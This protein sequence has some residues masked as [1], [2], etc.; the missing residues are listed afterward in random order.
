MDYLEHHGVKG[1]KWGVRRY[2]NPDGT[3]TVE[4]KRRVSTYA[5]PKSTENPY[6]KRRTVKIHKSVERLDAES[7]KLNKIQSVYGHESK[8]FKRQLKIQNN[9][10]GAY[11][12][13]TRDPTYTRVHDR[14]MVGQFLGGPVGQ[15]V[16]TVATKE[17][18]RCI[19]EWQN[20]IDEVA[21]TADFASQVR[22]QLGK[23]YID[24][25]WKSNKMPRRPDIY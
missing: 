9:A 13:A 7:D 1:Q 8:Q 20:R 2:Q 18:R 21:I 22:T 6:S 19:K 11:T 14:Q 25:A 17:G 4:G 23:D 10:A 15:I 3:L 5:K 12:V 24:E 16:A